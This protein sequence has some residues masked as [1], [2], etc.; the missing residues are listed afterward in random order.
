[1][2]AYPDR[3]PDAVP[4]VL[5]TDTGDD[6]DDVF[7]IALAAVS[8]RIDL[9][10]VVTAHGDTR[11]RARLARRVLEECGRGDVPVYAGE[12]PNFSGLEAGTPMVSGAG[13]VPEEARV[14]PGDGVDVLLQ[15]V[16]RAPGQIT[17]CAV[18]PLTNLAHAIR[19]DPGFAANAARL[20]IM[21][22]EFPDG[23]RGEYN[24]NCDPEAARVVIEAGA[25]TWLGLFGPTRRAQIGTVESARMRESGLPIGAS[26]SGMLDQYLEARER[27]RTPMFDGATLGELIWPELYSWRDGLVGA[28]VEVGR[29]RLR[30]G[31]HPAR[32]MEDLDEDRFCALM[33]DAI[34]VPA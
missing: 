5:D 28:D 1:L 10:A 33:L 14:E 31:P 21:G 12:R 2:S 27:V 13:F 34:L 4:V 24:F 29:L 22:G 15:L 11:A 26:L 6:V 7:A 20:L 9:R 17:V 23:P 32:L 8:P 18:G 16:N 19:Q 3:D 30:E 25:E